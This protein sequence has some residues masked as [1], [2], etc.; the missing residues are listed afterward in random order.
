MNLLGVELASMQVPDFGGRGK[1]A[2]ELTIEF[3]EWTIDGSRLR[4]TFDEGMADAYSTL[5]HD[6]SDPKD[7]RE[8]L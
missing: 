1:R 4:S 5:L 6:E 8:S 3:L 2:T 7:R